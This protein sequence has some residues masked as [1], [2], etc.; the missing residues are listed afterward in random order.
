MPGIGGRIIGGEAVLSIKRDGEI[1]GAGK[2]GPVNGNS[3]TSKWNVYLTL[4][5][6]IAV[7]KIQCLLVEPIVIQY[8]ITTV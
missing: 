5:H 8:F 2:H 4:C 6:Y 3:R 1:G 7:C